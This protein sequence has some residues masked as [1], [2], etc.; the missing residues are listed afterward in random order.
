VRTISTVAEVP[1]EHARGATI[2]VLIGPEEGAGRF[3]TRQFTVQPGGRIPEHR[4]ADIEHEQV[5]LE[6]EMVLCMNGEEHHVRAGDA[7][8]IPAGTR[9]WYENRGQTPVRFLCMVPS[10]TSYQTEWLE[11]A[12]TE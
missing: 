11:S 2:Q 5:V 6:G 7:I 3:F 8:F 4:H 10:S 1:V 9:H 12:P